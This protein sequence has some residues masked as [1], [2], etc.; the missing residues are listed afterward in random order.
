M[1]GVSISRRE[2]PD[3]LIARH[4]LLSRVTRR[5]AEADEEVVFWDEARPALLPVWLNGQ[6]IVLRWSGWRPVETLR[7][8]E[9]SGEEG[10]VPATFGCDNGIWYTMQGIRCAVISD[11][12]YPISQPSNH[13][14]EVMTRQKRMPLFVGDQI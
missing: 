1:F 8:G 11:I 12:V 4:K 5:F 14:Y 9:W 10:V 6:L 13:Y 3:V 7:A 2:F